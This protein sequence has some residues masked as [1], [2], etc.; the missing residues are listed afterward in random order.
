MAAD[1][2]ETK[3]SELDLITSFTGKEIVPMAYLGTNPAATLGALKVFLSDSSLQ[4]FSHIVD[5]AVPVG[6]VAPDVSEGT[7]AIVYLSYYKTF[8]LEKTVN[9]SSSY[10]V[11]FSGVENYMAGTQQVRQ[12][13]VFFCMSD[14]GMYIHDGIALV[15]LVDSSIQSQLESLNQ[16]I[17]QLKKEVEDLKANGGGSGDSG[18]GEEGGDNVPTTGAVDLG[19]AD[20]SSDAT[21]IDL[22]G[23]SVTGT[24]IV[25]LGGA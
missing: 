23:A 12:D 1:N 18:G 14:K 22:G 4:V 3:F 20:I 21:A 17:V 24:N 19:G 11:S 2:K 16:E 6:G 13:R 10:F 25:D 8:A 15:G 7:I 5:T 9:S